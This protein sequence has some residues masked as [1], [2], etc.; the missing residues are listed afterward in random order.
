MNE[1]DLSVIDCILSCIRVGNGDALLLNW[2]L[3]AMLALEYWDC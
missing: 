1:G 2:R 3:I